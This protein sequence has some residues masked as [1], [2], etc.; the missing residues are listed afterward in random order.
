M[1]GMM[2]GWPGM[3]PMAAM[4]GKGFPFPPMMNG[5]MAGFP[6]N[7]WEAHKQWASFA[8]AS[9]VSQAAN[10]PWANLAGKGDY[11]RNRDSRRSRSRGRSKGRGKGR[12]RSRSRS[13]GKEFTRVPLPRNIMG[14]VIGK[15]G[16]TI[17]DI[18]QQTGARIDAEDIN[19]DTC[20]FK[21]SGNPEAVEKAK[22]MIR[23]IVDKTPTG[24]MQ[25]AKDQIDINDPNTEVLEFPAS[26][27][28]RL[29][30]SKGVKIHE[31]RN[32]S[33]AKV[34]IEKGDVK[35]KVLMSG[36]T[37]QLERARAMVTKLAEEA[38][39]LNKP[40]EDGGDSINDS[41]EFPASATGA[42]IG[43][44]G[45]KIREIREESGAKLSVEKGDTHCKVLLSGTPEAIERAKKLCRRIVE[46]GPDR[47]RQDTRSRRGGTEDFMDVPKSL[48][49]RV[50]GKGGETIQRLQRE[51]GAKVDVNT[52]SGDPCRVHIQGDSEAVCHARF[53]IS[54][55]LEKGG[56][57]SDPGPSLPPPP[58]AGGYWPE[59]GFAYGGPPPGYPENFGMGAWGPPQSATDYKPPPD[60]SVRNE[61]DMDEL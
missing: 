20:E 29:I 27:T 6:S 14:R 21:I 16:A 23:D 58:P 46:E 26:V 13:E 50:I 11:H 55:I 37:D 54:E 45:S 3:F 57:R 30:G 17:N 4:G 15:G 51:S 8:A 40:S 42:I 60:L 48:V 24:S 32:T 5:D 31:L 43:T 9:Q 1:P 38:E 12:S 52:Q 18:R 25:D 39:E 34:Q 7:L 41:I 56:F 36:T 22:R 35:C 49:G 61:I 2:P 47:D 28:G 10:N 19:D 53:L 59:S 44:R 33:G